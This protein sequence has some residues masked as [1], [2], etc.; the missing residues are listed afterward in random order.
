MQI[1]DLI[2]PGS[3]DAELAQRV[4][5]EDRVE[6]QKGRM[7][8]ELVRHLGARGADPQVFGSMMTDKLFLSCAGSS[9]SATTSVR[10]WVDWRDRS[11]LRDGIPAMHYRL[12]FRRG[13]APLSRDER[14]SDVADVERIIRDAF[15]RAR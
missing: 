7:I 5:S 10:V 13:E 3:L 6:A 15:G 8:S 9:A 11:P 1:L 14:A 12:Q 4:S 2:E